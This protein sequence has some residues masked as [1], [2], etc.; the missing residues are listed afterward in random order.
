MTMDTVDLTPVGSI[1]Q[2][3]E[4]EEDVL[5][6]APNSVQVDILM[7]MAERLEAR[8]EETRSTDDLQRVIS[9]MERAL[10][11]MPDDY[12][13]RAS[14]LNNFAALL[15]YRFEQTGS[16]DDLDRVITTIEEASMSTIV[17]PLELALFKGNL[18]RMLRR[19]FQ[20]TESVQ[21]LNRAIIY[22]EEARNLT[23]ND[24]P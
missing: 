3:A 17:G 23:T 7:A 10:T 12:P 1:T 9:T 6:R 13:D 15:Q 5:E 19:R 24:D 8:F 2:S 11:Y 21:D 16:V 22:G 14:Y 18:N 4:L 20:L